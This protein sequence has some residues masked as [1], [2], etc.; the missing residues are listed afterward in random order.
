MV[1]LGFCA[2]QVS[3]FSL[4]THIASGSIYLDTHYLTRSFEPLSNIIHSSF[5]L[6]FSWWQL[7][8]LCYVLFS[9][10]VYPRNTRH[11]K[12]TMFQ[13][14]TFPRFAPRLE[15]G[16]YPTSISHRFVTCEN[17]RTWSSRQIVEDCSVESY[18]RMNQRDANS[19][20]L[21]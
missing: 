15:L 20:F 14:H 5:F 2:D 12:T 4:N 18:L 7:F 16:L 19:R 9:V 10:F 13:S 17:L 21:R 6:I 1:R 11:S 8:R 3:P